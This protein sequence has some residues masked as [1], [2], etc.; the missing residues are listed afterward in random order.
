MAVNNKTPVA[1]HL[2]EP[3]FNR[4][5]SVTNGRESPIEIQAKKP[6]QMKVAY[7]NRGYGNVSGAPAA[8]SATWRNFGNP[9]GAQR[10]LMEK[11]FMSRGRI[12]TPSTFNN[13]TSSTPSLSL[14]SAS[15]NTVTPGSSTGD[16]VGVIKPVRYL[17]PAVKPVEFQAVRKDQVDNFFLLN[18]QNILFYE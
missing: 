17:P 7:A 11:F 10:G 8:A 18:S 2:Q 16:S 3:S 14:P 9:Q 13:T 12:N 4:S 6:P 15:H 1:V 5:E